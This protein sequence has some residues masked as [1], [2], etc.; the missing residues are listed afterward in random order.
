MFIAIIKLQLNKK[1]I[2]EKS[3]EKKK[4]YKQ[5]NLKIRSSPSIETRSKSEKEKKK[6]RRRKAQSVHRRA[7]IISI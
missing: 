7:V 3:W 5:L 4:F 2:I 1:I 6:E